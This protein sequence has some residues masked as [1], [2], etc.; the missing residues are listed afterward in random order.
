M[1][2]YC[3]LQREVTLGK[4]LATTEQAEQHNVL[5]K[6]RGT[7][8]ASCRADWNCQLQQWVCADLLRHSRKLTAL[9]LWH[10]C[11]QK[12]SCKATHI[13][14]ELHIWSLAINT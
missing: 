2:P 14:E 13:L 7:Q 10:K 3:S 4:F 9:C 11:F 12:L 5:P 6:R 8:E 1:L